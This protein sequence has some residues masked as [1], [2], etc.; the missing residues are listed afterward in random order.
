MYLHMLTYLHNNFL[1]SHS[2]P[3]VTN[4]M[5]T[6]V[7]WGNVLWMTHSAAPTTWTFLALYTPA[8][9]DAQEGYWPGCYF[10]HIESQNTP[11]THTHTHTHTLQISFKI[12]W[13]VT[14]TLLTLS[15]LARWCK[16]DVGT[17]RGWVPSS[18]SFEKQVSQFH[19]S[20]SYEGDVPNATNGETLCTTDS[21]KY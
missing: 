4:R 7:S 11:H 19:L 21:Q 13:C 10:W 17:C 20:S 14:F 9:S 2:S 6:P 1:S 16:D 15:R 8:R 12:S 5:Q 3:S 18:K